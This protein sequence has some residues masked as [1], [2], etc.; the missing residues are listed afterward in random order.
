MKGIAHF[1]AGVAVATFFPEIVQ[2][3]AQGLAFGP[4]LGGIAGLLPDTLDFKLLRYL[5][6]PDEVIDPAQFSV[7][8]A[9]GPGRPD[10]QRMAARL[11][12]A[13]DRAYDSGRRVRVQMHTLRLGGDLW[14]RWS[15]QFDTAQR[16]VQVRMGP[17]VTTGQVPLADSA[18]AG[19]QAGAAPVR[20]PLLYAGG[21]EIVVDIFSGPSLAFQPAG[22]AVEVVFLPWHR[23]WT[24][25][26]LM[27]L[28][29]GLAGTVIAPVYGLAMALAVLAH[30]LVDQLG[31]MGSNLFFPLARRRIRGMGLLHSGDALPNF[32][33]VWISGALILFNLDRFSAQPHL[34]PGPYLFLAVA[35]PALLFLGATLGPRQQR[36]GSGLPATSEVLDEA[37]EVDI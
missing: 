23:A 25:S 22:D 28:L 32:L 5:D 26:L 36:H 30:A 14:Q 19:L 21:D 7:P 3:A 31:F 1:A 20:A 24:H 33:T 13:A 2:A 6:R 29:L 9:T 15:L 18:P 4:V 37:G 16:Q 10:P 35:L 27:A 11:A 17:A 8:S 34:P 12:A